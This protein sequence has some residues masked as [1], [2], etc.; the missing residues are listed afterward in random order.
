MS[1]LPQCFLDVSVNGKQL[2]RIVVE[3]RSD[4]VPKTVDNF[5]GLCTNRP[6]YGYKKTRFNRIIPGFMIQGGKISEDES[7][8]SIY[9]ERFEDENFQLNHVSPGTLSMANR[10][11]NTNGSSFFIT[12][13]VTD[14][15]DGKHV[16]FGKVIQGMEVVLAIE[17]LGTES[18]SPQEEIIIE[19]CGQL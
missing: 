1:S 16:V 10:G 5:I 18:G 9:G 11:P 8:Q 19:N 17:A 12:T 3:L 13:A 6:G 4:I 15:L 7:K 2:G 14:W